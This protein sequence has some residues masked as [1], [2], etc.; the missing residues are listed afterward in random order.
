MRRATTFPRFSLLPA[1]LQLLIW[2]F[3]IPDPRVICYSSRTGAWF[4]WNKYT[5][6]YTSIYSLTQT[7]PGILHACYD[8]R[9]EALKR[10][11]LAFTM[12]LCKP[13]Y[14][15]FARDTLEFGDF[16]A[17]DAFS[18][19]NTRFNGSAIEADDVR[20]VAITLG[21]R[22]EE[23]H[24]KLICSNFGAMEELKVR[25]RAAHWSWMGRWGED[26]QPLRVVERK[27]IEGYLP[28]MGLIAMVRWNVE[29]RGK[30]KGGWK[31]PRVVIGT[32]KQWELA[33][34]ASG[35]TYADEDE[36]DLDDEHEK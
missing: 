32:E 7:L 8:S 26:V 20:T 28:L 4:E 3:A 5:R 25:E 11:K 22:L 36:M 29:A 33:L 18:K 1:E 10:Y 27:E 34:K 19:R 16:A 17:F 30:V 13:V 23:H 9:K 6:A 35:A 24:F 14:F 2:E 15:D 12:E 31:A 21:P